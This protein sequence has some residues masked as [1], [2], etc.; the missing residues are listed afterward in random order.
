MATQKE[1]LIVRAGFDSTALASGLRSTVGQVQHWGKEIGCYIA[2]AFALEKLVEFQKGIFEF[3]KSISLTAERLGV[4]T[5]EVQKLQYAGAMTGV[6]LD[7]VASA[8]EKLARAKEKA[9]GGGAGGDQLIASFA[10]FGIT[11]KELQTLAPDQLFDKISESVEKTGVN[12][13]VTADAM[14]LMGRSGA[15]SPASVAEGILRAI[16][17]RAHHQRRRFGHVAKGLR[18]DGRSVDEDEGLFC[19][20]GSEPWQEKFLER[21]FQLPPRR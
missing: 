8:L 14:E 17:K 4:T 12:S 3:A 16:K 1:E 21:L 9:L 20:S 11:M 2:G 19:E 10:R 13:V 18:G 7:T 5:D 15:M 6:A